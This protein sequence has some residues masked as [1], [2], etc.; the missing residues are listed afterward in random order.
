MFFHFLRRQFSSLGFMYHS[1]QSFSFVLYAIW[2][3][4]HY[5]FSG[6]CHAILETQERKSFSERDNMRF[7]FV[8]LQAICLYLFNGF[9]VC[10]FCLFFRWQKHPEIIHIPDVIFYMQLLF[11]VMIHWIQKCNT[12]NLNHLGSWVVSGLASILISQYSA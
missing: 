3:E 1:G 9:G 8:D 11:D 6:V 7:L 12:G 5:N 2:I 4:C 10:L